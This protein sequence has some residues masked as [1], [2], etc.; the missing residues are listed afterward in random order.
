MK[1]M[2][3]SFI[4][5]GQ[6]SSKYYSRQT[7]KKLHRDIPYSLLVHISTYEQHFEHIFKYF[8]THKFK[9]VSV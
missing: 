4:T 1:S 8:L 3:K 7:T 2:K 9:H 6:V 5:S